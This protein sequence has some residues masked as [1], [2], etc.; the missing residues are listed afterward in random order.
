MLL[1]Q[2]L[3]MHGM[4]KIEFEN[5]E[6][7]YAH[8]G[9]N[10]QSLPVLGPLSL[11]VE[12]GEF[13]CVLGESGCGKST[14]MRLLAGLLEPTRGSV[15]VDGSPITGPDAKRGVVFQKPGLI[16]WLTVEKNLSLG[17]R[18][19]GE[20][21]PAA[22]IRETIQAVGLKGFERAK[23][24]K[25]SGGMAQRAA[26]ARALVA[27]PEIMLFD[28]PFSALDALTK[29]KMQSELLRIWHE[30]D[31]T[32][33]FVTHDIEEAVALATRIV[34]LTPR[35]GRIAAIKNVKLEH[36]RSRVSSSFARIRAMV[37]EDLGDAI[38]DAII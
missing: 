2:N 38:Q 17:F 25:L 30:E 37:A 22:R 19:R 4:A 32:V 7:T 26:I 11:P 6:V 8:H 34:V 31:L 33:I 3:L 23:P 29:L 28:E 15:L 20:S 1:A 21:V 14:L 16:P 36:P 35:P 13:L 24:H 5:A 9:G 18:I 12:Q 10:N 27:K